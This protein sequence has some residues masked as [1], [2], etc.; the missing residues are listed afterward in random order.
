MIMNTRIIVAG[1]VLLA[2]CTACAQNGSNEAQ[3]N[4]SSPASTQTLT[5]T[6][7][8]SNSTRQHPATSTP[9]SND[10]DATDI[11]S[12]SLTYTSVCGENAMIAFDP[13][14]VEVVDGEIASHDGPAPPFQPLTVDDV[15]E[16]I[17]EATAAGAERIK[18]EYGQFGQPTMVNIDYT[19]TGIDDEFCLFVTEFAVADL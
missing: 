12:Y 19:T 13:V 16:I 18:V 6:T 1:L 10:W 4:S 15:V 5:S 2:A 3:M 7:A 17:A 9:V 14:T 11:E 8:S